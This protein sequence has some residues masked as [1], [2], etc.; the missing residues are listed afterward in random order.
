MNSITK[1]EILWTRKCN[2]NCAYC[3]MAT[4]ESNSRSTKDWKTGLDNLKELGCQMA[5]FYGAEPLLDF[6]HLARTVGYA[7]GIGVNTTV[8]TGGIVPNLK[9]KLHSLHDN[10][11]RS[12]SMSYDIH[13]LGESSKAK[14]ELAVKTLLYFQSLGSNVRDTAAIVTLTRTNFTALPQTIKDMSDMGIW[15]FWD[16]IHPD[17]GQPGSKCRGDG[18]DLLFKQ[19]DI[20]RL[21]EILQEVLELKKDGSL[22][23]TTKEIIDT[24]SKNN[25]EILLKFNWKCNTSRE[26]PCFLTI[27]CDG[28]VRYCDDYHRT[29]CRQF[30]MV[31][32]VYEWEAFQTQARQ[33][34]KLC[35]GCAWGTHIGAEHVKEGN[36]DIHNYIHGNW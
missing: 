2:L 6:A 16:F 23:H 32:I 30:D 12:L 34:A 14:S 3:G 36:T 27:D 24:Y 25:Y 28:T 4:G 35:P 13:P 33:T 21:H 10:G 9:H 31:N 1:A 20:P 26:F 18:G 8:I 19:E 11:A 22:V 5:C 17:N 29:D 7:E 15:T